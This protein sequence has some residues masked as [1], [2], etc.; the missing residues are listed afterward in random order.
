MLI[1]RRNRIHEQFTKTASW[2]E[3]KTGLMLFIAAVVMLALL[4]A[5]PVFASNAVKLKVLVITTGD[6]TQDLGL[7][8]IKPVLDEMDVPYDVLNAETDDLTAAM[9]SS[10]PGGDGCT[11]QEE[12]CVG[13]YN[14]IIL[15][16]SDLVPNFT[17]SEWDIL[18]NY[19]KDFLVRKAVLSGWP[20]TYWD[21]NPPFG[22]YLDYGLAYSS[23]GADYE[24]QWAVPAAD[25]KAIFEY[26]NRNNPL[27][28]TD[29]AFAAVPRNDSM[30]PRD[31]SIPSVVPLLNTPSGEA[32][33]SV[34]RFMMPG[35]ATPVREVLISTITNAWFLT[36]SQVLAY[37]FVNWVTQGVFVGGRIVHMAAHLDDL[38]LNNDLWD[39]GL[40]MNI[41]P[42]I[43]P[44]A[45]RLNSEDIINGVNQQIA[46]RAAH[47]TAGNGFKLDFPFNGAGAVVDPEAATLVANLTED[48]VAAVVANKAHFR[49]I[50]HTFTHADMDKP[51]VPANAPC[52]Y[53]T[54]TTLAPIKQQ[55]T[56]NRVVWGLL[57]L[58]EKGNNN[59]VLVSGN[60]SGLKDRKCT[61]LAELHPEMA[62]VQDDDVPFPQGANPLFLE[63]A[64]DVGV[65]FVASDASQA[66]QAVEKYITEV[67]DGSNQD[68][69]MLPRWPT[70]V[71]Y[72]V[73]NPEQLVDE[74]NYIFYERFVN[75]GQDPCSIPG[76][77]CAP[78]DYAEILSAEADTAVRHMLSYKKWPHFFHQSNLA[79][80]NEGG[81][82]L[83]F[84][85]LDSVYT[86]YEQL[87]TL[88]VR[89]YPYYLIG[90]KTKER[91]IAKSA[92]VQ[93]I[94]DRTTNQITVSADKSV[95]NLRVTGVPG[96][97]FYG[98]QYIR[99]IGVNTTP[100]IFN[101]NQAFNE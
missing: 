57:G 77:I 99:E 76:A 45:Y 25:S 88:S 18:H 20:G 47:P 34:V 64:S 50:N 23:S 60:H 22:I 101:V 14:G 55:I 52:D 73:I 86:A 78:R 10:S 15:T 65:D 11:A 32:L 81:N 16:D 56:K 3:L 6:E 54:F 95:P 44:N 63:A 62:N 75:A 97:D 80:Y 13:N 98:G 24:G 31:G 70:N 59:R 89:N 40:N 96:G 51:P 35:Q 27:A 12:G 36:H 83:I 72:N 85:W 53:D 29:F 30:G 67:N 8:Y 92:I 82:T 66:N 58:P 90:D 100:K 46:F 39:P 19:Q 9:L 68:R 17:P 79:K 4:S 43:S 7:A 48:L 37:E 94:W 87:F 93:A 91:L 5:P 38:F 1:I 21:P 33:V 61:D 41:P 2:K 71:F 84:D 49:F 42:E 69:I 74:Y 26:V 28:V